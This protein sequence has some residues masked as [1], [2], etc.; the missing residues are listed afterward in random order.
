MR[1]QWFLG[2][3]VTVA[4]ASAASGQSCSP[5]SKSY[6]RI[7]PLSQGP[8]VA[9]GRVCV[10][11]VVRVAPVW[12]IQASA[13]HRIRA[14]AALVEAVGV[15]NYLTS[16]AMVRSMEAKR[17]AI[18]NHRQQVATYFDLKRSNKAYQ[19]SVN[20][21]A[22]S[23]VASNEPS[24]GPAESR[25][26]QIVDAETGRV[27]WPSVLCGDEYASHRESVEN[28][29]SAPVSSTA[30]IDRIRMQLRLAA[31]NLLEELALHVGDMPSSEYV[32]AKGFVKALAQGNGVQGT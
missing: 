13:A 25:R 8:R 16:E 22:R 20:R 7:P 28:L 31:T 6:G 26:P 23:T 12:G 19:A 30:D 9:C 4:S 10:A 5:N 27:A 14:A 2:V 17:L 1:W 32:A 3:V 21:P 15:H 24:R 18:E 29:L 11:P